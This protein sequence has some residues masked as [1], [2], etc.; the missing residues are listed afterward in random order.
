MRAGKPEPLKYESKHKEYLD[1]FLAGKKGL[2]RTLLAYVVRE[3][4]IDAYNREYTKSKFIMAVDIFKEAYADLAEKLV[5]AGA[6][7]DTDLIYFLTH[8]EIGELILKKKGALIKKALRRQ[9][10]FDEQKGLR[11]K[12]VYIGRP[13]AIESKKEGAEKGARLTGAALSLGE[14]TGMA[15]VVRTPEDAKNLKEGEIMVAAFTDIGWSPYYCLIKGLVTEVGSALS[16][17]AVVAREYALPVVANIADATSV[18]RTGD[19][20]WLNGNAGTVTILETA[21]T[22]DAGE[23][24]V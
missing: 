3:A 14:A 10:L 5:Q 21:E 2:G 24:A 22:E 17:G 9:R 8:G 19:C 4:R 16:H 23:T 20:L 7:P 18:I 12:E 15:R 11:F 1:R 13:Q 6:L